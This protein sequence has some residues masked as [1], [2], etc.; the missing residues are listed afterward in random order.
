MGNKI[1]REHQLGEALEGTLFVNGQPLCH[2]A[3]NSRSHVPDG[4]YEMKLVYCHQ[5]QRKMLYLSSV[6]SPSSPPCEL[7]KPIHGVNVNTAMPRYCPMIRAGN[8]VV[9]RKD[10]SILLGEKLTTGTSG[11]L[12][13]SRNYWEKFFHRTDMTLRRGKEVFISIISNLK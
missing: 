4:Q 6:K 9:K 5:Q 8:G 7:C 11:S 12:K 2:T 13:H 1:L 3:E 10:G